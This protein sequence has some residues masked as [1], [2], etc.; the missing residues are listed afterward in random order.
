MI[1]RNTDPYVFPKHFYIDNVEIK[2]VG[3][4]ASCDVA[5]TLEYAAD[6]Y[7][8]GK[9]L[10][11]YNPQAEKYLTTHHE[12]DM[13]TGLD[14]R[15]ARY[16]DAD[17]ARFLSLDERAADYPSLSSYNY[18]AGNP[19]LF[20]DPNGRELAIAGNFFY[21]RRV[22]H[23]LRGLTDD[24][25]RLKG[26]KVVIVNPRDGIKK[27][28]TKL[29]RDIIGDPNLA[30]IQGKKQTAKDFADKEQGFGFSKG[31]AQELAAIEEARGPHTIS[32]SSKEN[33]TNSMNG[34]G[35]NVV[36]YFSFKNNASETST[37]VDGSFGTEIFIVVGHELDHVRN[38]VLGILS[39]FSAETDSFIKGADG[40][41]S[42]EE[43][44]TRQFE[45][46]LRKENNLPERELIEKFKV[47]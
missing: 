3:A 16:Y 41:I 45:N 43:A 12:R 38:I 29:L 4:S 39:E 8:Y 18:V 28:G 5:Y 32:H 40:D 46:E 9:I 33:Q 37:N 2:E 21:K 20:L 14:Y 1:A 30:R 13:E 47:D 42:E 19:L 15:G 34:V 23:Q 10:R 31:Y 24:K 36:L 11:E 35:H 26:G 17:I 25:V 44:K 22:L 27:N 6:Y 7:P